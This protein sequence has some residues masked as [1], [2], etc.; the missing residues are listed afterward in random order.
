MGEVGHRFFFFSLMN[1][2]FLRHVMC[3]RACV[4]ACVC[5][6]VC[7]RER[8]SAHVCVC[9][10]VCEREREREREREHVCVRACVRARARAR[11]HVCVQVTKLVRTSGARLPAC[12]LGARTIGSGHLSQDMFPCTRR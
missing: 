10:C 3:V 2:H 4:H 6:R 9:V 1:V 7:A 8:E 11:V 5:V 12:R